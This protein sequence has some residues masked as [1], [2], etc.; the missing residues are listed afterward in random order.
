M[1]N[2]CCG[3]S[4]ASAEP[5]LVAVSDGPEAAPTGGL[6]AHDIACL[7]VER[8]LPGDGLAVEEV[9]PRRTG[10]AAPRTLR[11]PPAPLADERQ[12]AG[13]QRAQLAHDAVSAVVET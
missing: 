11:S 2:I 5:R 7:Q 8:G 10:L 3:G 13:L 12:A 4:T 9:A 1:C 6:D